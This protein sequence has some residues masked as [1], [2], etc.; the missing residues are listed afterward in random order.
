MEQVLVSVNQF[1]PVF[2]IFRF[3]DIGEQI[4]GCLGTVSPQFINPVI[5]VPVTFVF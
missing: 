2:L 1:F 3:I 5:Y 4:S